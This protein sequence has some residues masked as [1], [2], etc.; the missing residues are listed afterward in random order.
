MHASKQFE[1]NRAIRHYFKTSFLVEEAYMPTLMMNSPLARNVA[2][3]DVTFAEWSPTS[4]PHPKILM[5]GDF[6]ARL[7]SGK[8]FARKFDAKVDAFIMRLLDE[9]H[10]DTSCANASEAAAPLAPVFSATRAA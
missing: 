8:L 3:S 10:A 5:T 4:G 7:S 1:S 9:R 2:G 6:E